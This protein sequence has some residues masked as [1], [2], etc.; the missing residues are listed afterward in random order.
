MKK[1]VKKLKPPVGRPEVGTK[2]HTD[3]SG[4]SIDII[5]D[6]VKRGQS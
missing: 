4:I 5:T 3:K 6:F 2:S 1:K